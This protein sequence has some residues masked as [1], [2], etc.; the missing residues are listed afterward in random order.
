MFI[1]SHAHIT[2]SSYSDEEVIEV[3]KRAKKNGV[4]FIINIGTDN[5]S[6]SR[7]L[8]LAKSYP[9]VKNAVAITPHDVEKEGGL[10][11]DLF[12]DSIR[13]GLISAVGETGL[14]YYYEHSNRKIQQEYFIRY[15]T[16]ASEMNLP[17]IIHC[18]NAFDDLF[19]LLDEY[20]KTKPFVLHCFTGTTLEAKAVLD[21]GGLVSFSG[22]VTFKK[23]LDLQKTLQFIPIE[24]LLIETDSP[25]LAP[26][27]LR[28][29][30]NEP[31][32]LRIIAQKAADLKS[33]SL[34]QFAYT[35]SNNA[36]NF[37]KILT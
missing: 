7:G 15:L 21:R 29:K 13:S 4:D 8:D 24:S 12:E 6:L 9:F 26:E 28:G 19:L 37:F 32:N 2:S 11:F 16:L 34:E 10:L 22:I 36:K 17:L 30:K 18:R 20:Y 14:D 33:V 23:S 31:S 27:G 3:T 35:T 25:Y 5:L 1:D